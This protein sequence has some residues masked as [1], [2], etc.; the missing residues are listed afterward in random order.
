[1]HDAARCSGLFG[2]ADGLLGLVG[3]SLGP[4]RLVSARRERAYL[5]GNDCTDTPL[6]HGWRSVHLVTPRLRGVGGELAP[7][8]RLEERQS[9]PH[10]IITLLKSNPA[11]FVMHVLWDAHEWR[12]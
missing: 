12:K 5:Y 11:G 6:S 3:G 10:C 4:P 7:G 9:V 1:M 8:S 2:L